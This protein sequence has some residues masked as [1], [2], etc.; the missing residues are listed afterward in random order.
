MEA[1]DAAGLEIAID[2]DA[3]KGREILAAID[4][5]A[6]HT[7]AEK[8]PGRIPS[9][10]VVNGIDEFAIATLGLEIVFALAGAPTVIPALG[11]EAHS[12]PFVLADIR[13]VELV[14]LTIK[15]KAPGIPE[16]VGPDFGKGIRLVD[17]G[18][19]GGHGIGRMEIHVQ[20]QDFPQIGVCC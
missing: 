19:V 11:N 8:I 1:P 4:V 7:H 6:G 16:A 5:P 3:L 14:G 12:L 10:I 17:K 13:A 18:I 20:K 9:A 15:G 2:V